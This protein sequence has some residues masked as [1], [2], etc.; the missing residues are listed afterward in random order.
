MIVFTKKVQNKF[1]VF[2]WKDLNLCEDI[3]VK[4]KI[5]LQDVHSNNT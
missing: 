2:Y 3:I 5:I 4:I 1:K